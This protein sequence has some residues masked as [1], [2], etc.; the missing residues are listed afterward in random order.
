MTAIPRFFF[1]SNRGRFA[2]LAPRRDLD[3]PW[4]AAGIIP[5]GEEVPMARWSLI[6]WFPA[7]L[8]GCAIQKQDEV[9]AYS[10]DGVYLFQMG[11]YREAR[12][13]FLKALEKDPNNPQLIYNRAQ[14]EDALGN[15][16][17]AER[18]YNLALQL[19]PSLH[20]ARHALVV[21]WNRTGR[22]EFAQ[23]QVEEWM[24]VNPQYAQ[25]YSDDGYLWLQAGDVA[26]AQSRLQQA[27]AINPSDLVAMIELGSI[28]ESLNRPDR[29]LALY[30]R[31]LEVR[32]N[33]A[34]L[35]AKVENMKKSGVQL[36]VPD[37]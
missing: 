29:A 28:Y 15:I 7:L 34:S 13:Y 36:P 22:R 32:P 11:A 8:A 16:A 4:V 17:E 9:R 12:Q 14:A 1:H 19:D 33:Q 3:F 30:E 6:F 37:R 21:L 23:K 2:F 24:R 35:Q 31:A 10:Q 26:R 18:L 5:L 20:Q 25:A 27:L